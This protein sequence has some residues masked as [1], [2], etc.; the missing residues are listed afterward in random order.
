VVEGDEG[1]GMSQ[2]IPFRKKYRKL[3][4]D[5]FTTVRPDTGSNYYRVGASY[6]VYHRG[7]YLF[8]ATAVRVVKGVRLADV[9][10]SVVEGDVD[11]PN[12]TPEAF[13][14]MMERMYK[15]NYYRPDFWRGDD[16]M[17]QIIWLRRDG[18]LERWY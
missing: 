18:T 10:A 16:T 1:E 15:E 8:S 9:P 3:H 14:A 11:P 13:R 6:D 2:V 17:F 4:R 7:R 12:N 5:L